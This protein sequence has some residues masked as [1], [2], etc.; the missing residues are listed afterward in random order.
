MLLVQHL[1][2]RMKVSKLVGAIL[3]VLIAL[4]I[5]INLGLLP[6]YLRKVPQ[7]DRPKVP[8]EVFTM[9]G[10][11]LRR[12]NP[13]SLDLVITPNN[14]SFDSF[15]LFHNYQIISNDN[16]AYDM[17]KNSYNI[18]MKL[19]KDGLQHLEMIGIDSN[20]NILYED[21]QFWAGFNTLRVQVINEHN[22]SVIHT[23]V[24]LQ[25]IEDYT[26]QITEQTDVNGQVLFENIP[27]QNVRIEC[28]SI[29]NAYAIEVV[30]G[31]T[32]QIELQLEGFNEPNLNEWIFSNNTN[33]TLISTEVNIL[34]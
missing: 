18:Q 22:Q 33:V 10:I 16:C 20:G 27:S 34:S 26:A 9:T 11:D 23:P 4:A 24:Y 6:W 15:S 3:G 1:I 12:F 7:T 25:L 5:G 8:L 13:M 29:D 31:P 2:E 17:K 14:A 19:T 21:V 28:N 30:I 32:N